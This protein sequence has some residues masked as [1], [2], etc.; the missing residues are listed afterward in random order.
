MHLVWATGGGE[1]SAALYNEDW[2]ASVDGTWIVAY[3]TRDSQCVIAPGCQT[4]NQ[5]RAL[6]RQQLV[7]QQLVRQHLVRQHLVRQQ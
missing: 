2:A 1:V 7:R 6:V 4:R 3:E 5:M